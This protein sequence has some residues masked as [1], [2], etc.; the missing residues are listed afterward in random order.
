MC[1]Y[2][3]QEIAAL[4]DVSHNVWK[5]RTKEYLLRKHV[6]YDKGVW[7]SGL[8]YSGYEYAWDGMGP[9]SEPNT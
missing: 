9:D 6:Q 7:N 2:K 4:D 3:S 5:T 1:E 8:S